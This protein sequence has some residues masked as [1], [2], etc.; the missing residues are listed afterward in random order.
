MKPLGFFVKRARLLWAQEVPSLNLGAPGTPNNI[1]ATRKY[2]RDFDWIASH[3]KTALDLY[4][5]M[6]AI[7]PERVNPA[8]L[9]YQAQAVNPGL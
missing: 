1:Q 8:V 3:N 2:I 7:Y 5:E 6:L 9:W 4:N